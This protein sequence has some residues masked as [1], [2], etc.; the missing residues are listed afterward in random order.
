MVSWM[1]KLT[2]RSPSNQSKSPFRDLTCSPRNSIST[3]SSE[4]ATSS[5]VARPSRISAFT[6]RHLSNLRQ[7]KKDSKFHGWKW[8]V[9]TGA[10]VT[11]FVL[12]ANIVFTFTGVFANS[13]YKNGVATLF[14]GDAPDISR[15]NSLL[16]ILIN[17][18]S[19]LLL[20]AS[21]YVMQV[22]SAPT[23]TECVVAH[24]NGRWLD[25]GIPSF[26]NLRS[27]SKKRRRLWVILGLSS[28]P[29]HLW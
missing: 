20:S 3:H 19:T 18:L 13:G 14:A 28:I 1:M 16:H 26:R 4:S 25:I 29:L 12:I 21:N 2:L 23:R 15:K 11:T 22:L 9:F 24:R 6:A 27:I 10:C 17:V 8:G 7:W 5:G